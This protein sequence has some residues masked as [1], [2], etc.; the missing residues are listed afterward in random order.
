MEKYLYIEADTNDADYITTFDQINDKDLEL[1]K[2]VIEAIKNFKPYEVISKE[3][4]N[5]WTHSNNF[6]IGDCCRKKLGEKSA[7]ELYGHL[8]GFQVFLDDY[9]PYNE[10]G[11]HTIATVQIVEVINVETLLN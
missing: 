3:Y 4:G 7:E 6:P 1:I 9:V 2:P 10:Y 5:M 8:E 11:I